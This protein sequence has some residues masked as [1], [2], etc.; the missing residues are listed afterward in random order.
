[1]QKLENIIQTK[2]PSTDTKRNSLTEITSIE[3]IIGEPEKKNTRRNKHIDS[4]IT[5]G[6]KSRKSTD[7]SSLLSKVSKKQY[8]KYISCSY[9]R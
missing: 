6:K 4:I 9:K 2:N 3:D 5:K 8:G 1:M 7:L